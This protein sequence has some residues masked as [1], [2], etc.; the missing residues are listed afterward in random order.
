VLRGWAGAGHDSL[1][2]ISRTDVK[3]VLPASGNDRV[4]IGSALRSLFR[5]LKAHKKVFINPTAQLPIGQ[6][7]KNIPTPLDTSVLRAALQSP[8]PAEALAIALIVFH[9]LTANQI[10]HIQL[11]DTRDGRQRI[12]DR[13]IPLAQPVRVRL[14]AYLNYRNTLWPNTRNP[15]LFINRRSAP[16]LDCVSESWPLH[17][18]G[19]QPRALR[20]DRVLAEIQATGD[21]RRLCDLFGLSVAGA[22]RYAHSIDQPAA[23]IG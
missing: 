16:R 5:I 3:A 17:Q 9:A 1:A 19:L 10:R 2:E 23:T 14:A 7:H 6:T 8:Q 18:T 4:Y 22:S 11:T 13:N 15:H 21:I 12:G 20:Q